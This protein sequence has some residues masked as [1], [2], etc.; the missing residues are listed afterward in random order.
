MRLTGGSRVVKLNEPRS[1][2]SFR[3]TFRAAVALNV[4]PTGNSSGTVA[5]PVS[6]LSTLASLLAPALYSWAI[7]GG[8]KPCDRIRLCFN[9]PPLL[10]F[11]GGDVPI[12]GGPWASCRILSVGDEHRLLAHIRQW[13]WNFRYSSGLRPLFIGPLGP[14]RTGSPH[15]PII[16][17]PST[18]WLS[19][20]RRCLLLV[21]N[22]T[23]LAGKGVILLL[24][25][26]LKI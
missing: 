21:S 18:I 2:S 25:V 12:S 14:Q 3:G 7:L 6:F 23:L 8:Y 5:F 19:V 15:K 10:R 13:G 1:H 22:Q 4:P 24:V 26:N 11:S 20:T 9:F 16:N 17:Q